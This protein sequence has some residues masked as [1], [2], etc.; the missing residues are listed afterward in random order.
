[1]GSCKTTKPSNYFQTLPRDTSILAY[2]DSTYNPAIRKYDFLAISISSMNKEMDE[3]FNAAASVSLGVSQTDRNGYRVDDNGYI[4]LHY[5]GLI[6]AEG[7]TCKELAASI[8]KSLE[9]Y[10]KEPIAQV[11]FLNLKLTVM[12]EVNSPQVLKM[13]SG[14]M[15]IL[16]AIAASGDLKEKANRTNIMVIRDS[17]DVRQVKR[18]NLESHEVMASPWYYLKPN[19]IVM[20][21]PRTDDLNK[22]ERRRTLQTTLSLVASGLSLL[23]IILTRVIN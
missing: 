14:S 2:V 1:M 4:M 15:T 3:K 6:K 19:D 5:A 18:I 22:E 23:T 12:G 11:Q 9:P 10:M 21:V 7:L 20:V 13:T 16:E 8:Q 17:N